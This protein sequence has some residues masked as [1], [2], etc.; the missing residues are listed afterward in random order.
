MKNNKA[1]S[2]RNYQ[3]EQELCKAI[4]K[5]VLIRLKYDTD[6][7]E[8]TFA[9][10]GVYNSNTGKVL[11]CGIQTDNPA[12]PSE[13]DKPRNLEVGKIISISLTNI[14]FIPDDRFDP[15]DKKYRNGFIERID[16]H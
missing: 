13:H 1:I 11:V 14:G 4:S 5:R 10:Y 16:N 3:F 8:R 7:V 2:E 6:T 15:T 12:D 9:P